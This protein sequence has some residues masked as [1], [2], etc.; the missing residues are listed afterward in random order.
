MNC[1][2]VESQTFLILECS[3]ASAIFGGNVVDSLN[4]RRN[5]MKV[6]SLDIH[7]IARHIEF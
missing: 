5:V 7:Q 3:V 4:L 6:F 1:L 2:L